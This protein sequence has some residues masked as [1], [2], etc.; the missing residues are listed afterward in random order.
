MYNVKKSKCIILFLKVVLGSNV[1][2][3]CY[4]FYK[5]FGTA[6]KLSKEDGTN[7]LLMTCELSL[8]ISKHY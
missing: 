4:M 6:K 1:L 8:K 5:C 2:K 3:M 7:N